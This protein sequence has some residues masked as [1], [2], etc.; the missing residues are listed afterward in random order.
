VLTRTL[1]YEIGSESSYDLGS[2][3]YKPNLKN[4][5]YNFSIYILN[6]L[7]SSFAI[8]LFLVI[9]VCLKLAHFGAR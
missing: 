6:L 4:Y 2:A 5:I 7:A 1:L 8:A 9:P 3:I